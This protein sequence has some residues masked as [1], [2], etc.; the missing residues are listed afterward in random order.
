M[1][2]QPGY[3]PFSIP[4]KPDLLLFR[5]GGLSGPAIPCS[6]HSCENVLV[7]ALSRPDKV[8]PTEW[9]LQP[10]LFTMICQQIDFSTS[11]ICQ[12][13]TY[14]LPVLDPSTLAVYTLSILWEVLSMYALLLLVLLCRVLQ[15]IQA[16]WILT[17]IL[18]VPWWPVG[19]SLPISENP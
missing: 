6:A 2:L 11:K 13:K 4:A 19:A 1:P 9:Q 12:L 5:P 10:D 17:L 3:S 8:A 18:V 15:E 7:D 14:I 16:T